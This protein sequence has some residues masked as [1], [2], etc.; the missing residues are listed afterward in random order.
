MNEAEHKANRRS[1]VIKVCLRSGIGGS[2]FGAIIGL[3]ILSMSNISPII[4]AIIIAGLGGALIGIYSANK[5]LA[6]FV[7]PALKIADF[8]DQVSKG[9]LT[10]QVEGIESD[11]MALVGNT[12]NNMVSTLR[13]LISQTNKIN[14]LVTKSSRTL[15]DLSKQ[16]GQAAREVSQSMVQIAAGADEQ[17]YSTNNTSNLIINLAEA[18]NSVAD[19]TQKSVQMAVNTQSAIKEGIGAV[20]LQNVKMNESYT[21][22]EAVS[23]AVQLLDENSNKI[24]QIVEVISSIADQTNLLAL[25][26]AIEAARAGEQGRGFAVVADEVRKLAEQ[27]ALSAHEIAA[28]IKQMQFNTHQVVKDMDDTRRVYQHQ[29]EAIKSTTNVFGTIVKGVQ[30][31]DNEITEISSATEEMSAS[32]DDLVSAVKAVSEIAHLTAVNARDVSKLTDSQEQALKSIILEIESLNEN[33]ESLQ[34]IVSTFKI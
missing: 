17:A 21:A 28:L 18:I 24:G 29:A 12:M 20:D 6:E 34:K 10:V 32:T 19:N 11:Q 26:A 23:K 31:I 3:A 25:N 15:V 5:N 7:D 1:M 13:D 30:N 22:L 27:S 33:T 8:A 4:L 9:D 16:S 14:N 2:I